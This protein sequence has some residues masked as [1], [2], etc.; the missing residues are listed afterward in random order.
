MKRLYYNESYFEKIDTEDKAYFLGFLYADGSLINDPIKKRYKIYLKLHTK[1]IHILYSFIK[2]IDGDMKPWKHGQRNISQ[3]A[4]SGRKIVADLERIG[5]HPNKTF[6]IKYPIIDQD[7]ERH[8]IRG[9]FDGDGCIRVKKDKKHES[10]Y[11]DLRFVSGSIDMLNKINERM[12]F[13]FGTNINNIY[14]PKNKNYKYIGWASMKDIELIYYAFY[15]NSNFF[16]H[17]KRNIF[18]EVIK[19]ISSKKKYRKK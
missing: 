18:D 4:L 11:G 14:G 13:L 6:T 9:Y 8:F 16:L 2:C 7:L 15:K 3:V 17:R 10:K 12:N 5:L 19:I 1:D